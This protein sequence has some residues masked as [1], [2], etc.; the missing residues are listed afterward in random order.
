M[1]RAGLLPVVGLGV[2]TVV[3]RAVAPASFA[4]LGA[5]AYLVAAT[6]AYGDM[7]FRL[8]AEATH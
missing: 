1:L 4:D 2:M 8:K 6:V 3:L 7:S 5:L